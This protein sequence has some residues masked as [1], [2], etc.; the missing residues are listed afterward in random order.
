MLAFVAVLSLAPAA[1]GAQLPDCSNEGVERWP[2]KTRP[3][4]A[5]GTY[6]PQPATI[7][8]I[9]RW[10]VPAPKPGQRNALV[11]VLPRE[12]EVFALTAYVRKLKQ[13]QGDCDLHLEMAGNRKATAPKI[14]VEIPRRFLAAQKRLYADL[15][16]AVKERNYAPAEAPLITVIGYGFIDFSHYSTKPGKRKKGNNHGSALVGTI[17][18]LHPVFDAWV[19]R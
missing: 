9:I 18:E 3:A 15:G 17:W 13:D 5:P 8:T 14:I 11:T 10:A 1:A 16:L 4:P 7:S 2:V 12:D 6:T 19:G